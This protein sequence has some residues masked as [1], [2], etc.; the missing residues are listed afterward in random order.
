MGNK[1]VE[2]T[3][4][5]TEHPYRVRQTY[6]PLPSGADAFRRRSGTIARTRAAAEVHTPSPPRCAFKSHLEP[7]SISGN[8]LLGGAGDSCKSTEGNVHLCARTSAARR[9][10]TPP[11]EPAPKEQWRKAPAASALPGCEAPRGLTMGSAA[12]RP[13][14]RVRARRRANMCMYIYIYIM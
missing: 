5:S 14:E 3:P 11:S 10:M 13:R 2:A 7:K 4:A 8:T 6:H 1:G 9:R 12:L